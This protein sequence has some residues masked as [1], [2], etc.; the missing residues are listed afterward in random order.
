MRTGKTIGTA[1]IAATLLGG[2]VSVSA[3]GAVFGSRSTVTG[4]T[5]ETR[6][7]VHSA[8]VGATLP[9]SGTPPKP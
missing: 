2:C 3:G 4:D 6:T 7:T 1:F 5:V 8:S 9:P